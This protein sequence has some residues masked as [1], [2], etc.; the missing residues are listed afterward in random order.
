MRNL[1]QI[2]FLI[3]TQTISASQEKIEKLVQEKF[4]GGKILVLVDCSLGVKKVES[5]GILIQQIQNSPDA[6]HPLVAVVATQNEGVWSFHEVPANVS[7]EKGS[8]KGFLREFWDTKSGFKGRFD[9]KCTT[10]S[11]DKKIRVRAN[12]MFVSD[13]HR[14][15]TKSKHLCFQIDSVYNSWACFGLGPSDLKLELSFVQ[16]NAD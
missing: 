16:M 5:K 15:S 8:V 3:L 7:Y 9:M 13:F 6:N 11:K 1:I 14:R 12:G 2:F 4:P 10:P